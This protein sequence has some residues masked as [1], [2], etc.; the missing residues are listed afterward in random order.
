MIT[1]LAS[2]GSKAAVVACPFNG[3]ID[4]LLILPL[5]GYV[6]FFML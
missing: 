1:E 4:D 2:E 6:S 5:R 3:Y